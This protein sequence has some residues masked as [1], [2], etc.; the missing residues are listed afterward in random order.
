MI[1]IPAI[2][3]M[4]GRCVRLVRG[5][6]KT[7]YTVA[8]DAVQTAQNF[9]RAGADWLHMVDLN[10]AVT[11]KPVNT[12]L[13]LNVLAGCGLKVEI[14]GGIRTMETIDFYMEKGVSRVILGSAAI[15]NPRLVEEAV[16]RYGEKIAVGIDANDEG[17]VAA[18]GWTTTSSIHYLELGKRMDAIGVQYMIFTDISRDGTLGGPNFTMLDKLNHAV[19]SQVIASGGVSSLKDIINLADLQL[20]GAICGKALYSGNL[21]LRQAVLLCKRGNV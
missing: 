6:Y 20:Y 18:E 19:S 8:E 9:E 7:A 13:I 15:N 14:G 17:M 2:D 11:T 4:D 12:D 16:K 10:G 1:V 3:I 21:S 5:N